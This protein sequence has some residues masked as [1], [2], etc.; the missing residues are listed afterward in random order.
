MDLDENW[1]ELERLHH[2]ADEGDL[3]EMKRLV[4]AG[5]DMA[6]FDNLGWTPLHHA[7]NAEHYK[8]ALWLIDHGADVNANDEQSAGETALADAVRKGCPE[9]V[10]LLLRKGADPDITGGM[11]NT[12]RLRAEWR[13]DG[14]GRQIAALIRKYRPLSS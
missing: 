11:A 6:M 1:Y 9:I 14:A 10:E 5:Y 3:G 8:A 12:A 13:N 2:A 7:V 4:A